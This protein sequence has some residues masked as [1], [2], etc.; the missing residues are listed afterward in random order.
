MTADNLPGDKPF[1]TVAQTAALLGVDKATIYRAIRDD[2]FPAIKVRSRYIVPAVAVEKLAQQA[3]E[4][5]S[6]VD[7]AALAAERRVLRVIAAD[8]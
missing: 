3:V 1:Y 7:V 2:A 4:T 6:V 8:D 5:G